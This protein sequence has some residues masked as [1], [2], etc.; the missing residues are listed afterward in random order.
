MSDTSP[1]GTNRRRTDASVTP[2]TVVTWNVQGSNGVDVDGIA[3]VVLAAGPDIVAIQ[4]I[5]RR[6]ARRLGRALGMPQMRWAFKNLA[7]PRPEGLAVFTPHRLVASAAFLL[8]RAWLWNWR[9]RIAIDATVDRGGELL[10]IVN[11]HLSPHDAAE[12]RRREAHIV[13]ERARRS[14]QLPIIA[15]DCNDTADGP[16]PAQFTTAGWTDAWLLDKLADV[17][18]STNWTSGARRGRPPTQRLDYVFAPPG[19]TVLDA[20]VMAA[21]DRLDWFAERSDHVPVTA[22]VVV[23]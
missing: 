11:V 15:G 5:Q 12:H 7:W 6:Q 18:G 20:A 4:E 14:P 17:D 13:I 19:S 8:R 10:A 3:Q 16:G 1:T 23:P 22:T 9:R 2:I 21:P